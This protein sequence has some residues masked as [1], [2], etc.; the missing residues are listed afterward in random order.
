MSDKIKCTK[1]K[2]SLDQN[3]F[4]KDD[5]I[6][7]MCLDCRTYSRDRHNEYSIRKSEEK[8]IYNELHQEEID[9]EKQEK[10]KKKKE[11]TK[12]YNKK[13]KDAN[14]DKIKE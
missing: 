11:H 3:E 9:N 14:K 13:Y 12:E 10:L 8:K 4:Q 5:K 2:K 1:C 6:Y 7:H